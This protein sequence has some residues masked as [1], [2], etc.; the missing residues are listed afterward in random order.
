MRR[1][2]KAKAPIPPDPAGSDAEAD[3]IDDHDPILPPLIVPYTLPDGRQ[4]EVVKLRE[5]ADTF[6]PEAHAAALAAYRPGPT[7]NPFP[8]ADDTEPCVMVGHGTYARPDLCTEIFIAA[9]PA[10]EP[11]RQTLA[12]WK[13]ML[14]GVRVTLS[15]HP[16]GAGGPKQQIGEGVGA[17]AWAWW[18]DGGLLIPLKL[19]DEIDGLPVYELTKEGPHEEQ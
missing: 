19:V 14:P 8:P 9:A 10:W 4:I 13:L 5:Y 2:K 15:Y 7:L 18:Q 16:Q 1:G 12:Y 11:Q 3:D 6:D 17:P